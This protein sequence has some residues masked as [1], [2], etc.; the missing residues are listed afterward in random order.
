MQVLYRIALLTLVSLAIG[1]C[2]AAETIAAAPTEPPYAKLR[3]G[4]ENCRI[5]FT[6]DH[7]GRVA[8]LG[9]SI[10]EMTGWR[11]LVCADLKTRFPDTRFDFVAA[12]ISSLGSTPHAFRF[13]RDVLGRGPVDLLF[14]EAAVND[15]TNGFSDSAQIRAM[16]GIVRQARTA[17]P[18]IDIIFLHF[19]DPEKMALYRKG[20]TPPVIV[21]HEKVAE[22]YGIP[23]IDLAKEVTSRIDAGEFTWAQF[24]DL[25]PSP[26]GHGIYQRSIGRLFDLAWRGPLPEQARLRPYALPTTP[27]DRWNYAQG[28]L[29]DLR[30]AT[31]GDG[32]QLD[33]NWVPAQGGTRPG[34]VKVPML[35]AETPGAML[36]F[37]FTGT[38]VGIFVAAGYDAGKVEY[39]IDDRPARMQDLFTPWSGGLHL[40]WAYVLDDELPLDTHTLT[41]RLTDQHHP[42]SKGT[43]ARLVYFLVNG[44][45]K[46]H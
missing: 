5:R 11:D 15:S 30:E 40:P 36:T 25:H 23:S 6:R 16:E 10:T 38:A 7:E 18:R 31:L 32:W 37:K 34:F 44:S 26:F 43:A 12:G 3:G 19:V 46:A 21:N 29:V 17:N 45:D 27:L 9:G 2:A 20:V 13:E 1:V 39:R 28:R 4:L 24:R 22:Y 42:N 33:P 8:F 35:V 14:V 41:L